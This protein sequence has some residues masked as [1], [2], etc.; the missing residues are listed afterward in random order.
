MTV[1]TAFMAD[2][3]SGIGKGAAF[4]NIV[5]HEEGKRKYKG[6]GKQKYNNHNKGM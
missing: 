6:G 4:F 3:K 2:H 1:K 5:L